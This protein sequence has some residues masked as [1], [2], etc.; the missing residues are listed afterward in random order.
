MIKL[1]IGYFYLYGHTNM[2]D[3]YTDIVFLL[4]YESFSTLYFIVTCYSNNNVCFR[5]LN[6]YVM[7]EI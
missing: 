4:F 3:A 7:K 5:C 2:I 6:S 1:G